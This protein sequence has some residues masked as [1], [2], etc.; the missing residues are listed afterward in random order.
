MEK[1]EFLACQR[2]GKDFE[3]G[4]E[5]YMDPTKHGWPIST[6]EMTDDGVA[7]WKLLLCADA[8]DEQIAAYKKAR[9]GIAAQRQGIIAKGFVKEDGG[10]EGG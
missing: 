2:C 9:E 7:I 4:R 8:T 5:E 10:A 3:I 1:N 6:G